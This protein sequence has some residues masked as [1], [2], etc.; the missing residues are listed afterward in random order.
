MKESYTLLP[1]INNKQK[2]EYK[3]YIKIIKKKTTMSIKKGSNIKK[4]MPYLYFKVKE[5]YR[6]LDESHSNRN[7]KT[8]NL[9]NE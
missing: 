9:P 5:G 1:P 6:Q 4:Y 3:K 2:A 8:L 7:K